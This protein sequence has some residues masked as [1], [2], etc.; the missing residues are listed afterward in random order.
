[1][2]AS[3]LCALLQLR[4]NDLPAQHSIQLIICRAIV[5]YCVKMQKLTVSFIIDSDTPKNNSSVVFRHSAKKQ[6]HNI[7]ICLRNACLLE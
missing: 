4:I 6:I 1:M 3:T 7:L 5:L 2:A